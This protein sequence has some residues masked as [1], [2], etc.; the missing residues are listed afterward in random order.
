M[1]SDAGILVHK[2]LLN[3]EEVPVRE[4][5]REVRNQRP[6]TRNP[7]SPKN[8]NGTHLISHTRVHQTKKTDK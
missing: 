6:E 4:A 7:E 5:V 3:C 2:I 1:A 8:E